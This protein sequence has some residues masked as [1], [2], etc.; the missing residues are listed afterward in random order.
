VLNISWDPDKLHITADEIA[1]DFARKKPRIAIGSRYR[2][3]KTSLNI[4]SGQMQPGNDKIVAD[5]IF[6]ILSQKRSPRSDAMIAPK[7]KIDGHW[8]VTVAFFNSSST[9]KLY[10]EQDGNWIQGTH[11]SDFAMQEVVGMVEGEQVKLRSNLRRPGDGITYMFS[12]TVTEDSISGSIYLGEY[13]NAKFTAK[14]T[15]YKGEHKRVVIPGG[16]PLAT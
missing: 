14:R 15:N 13:L 16:P 10:L 12:G 5:R 4:T 8:D 2:E 3:G 11:T 9:H 1:E 6:A 7:I